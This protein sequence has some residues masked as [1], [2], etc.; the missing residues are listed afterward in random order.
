MDF[1]KKLF[2]MSFACTGDVSTLVKTVII[3]IVAD[4][5]VGLAVSLIGLAGIEILSILVGAV[6]SIVGLYATAGI[7]FSFLV[8]FKVFK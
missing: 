7:V 3:Y 4:I 8:H 1:L 6:G 2:P 5:L